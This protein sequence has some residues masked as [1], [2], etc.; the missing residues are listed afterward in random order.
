M[1]IDLKHDQIQNIIIKIGLKEQPYRYLAMTD[2][3][4]TY[5][6]HDQVNDKDVIITQD[7]IEYNKK[8][9]DFTSLTGIR[10]GIHI[11]SINNFKR[12]HYTIHLT[13]EPIFY[14]SG[15]LPPKSSITIPIEFSE[16]DLTP[17]HVSLKYHDQYRE[18]TQIL[19]K[20]AVLPLAQKMLQ[21]LHEKGSIR[22]GDLII[23]QSG[24]SH[25]KKGLI[26]W[27]EY[28]DYKF[29]N[30]QI[31]INSTSKS[32]I[33]SKQFSL[34]LKDTWNAVVLNVILEFITSNLNEKR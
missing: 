32:L 33:R 22:I 9:L 26:K 11:L 2:N 27:D 18:M 12:T 23:N 25:S 6:F 34:P 7:Y 3:T 13:K 20:Q 19:F 17:S 14:E 15:Y 10:Y 29:L 31:V 16:G 5:N 8:H 30:G 1:V 4:E 24:I 28:R 21:E